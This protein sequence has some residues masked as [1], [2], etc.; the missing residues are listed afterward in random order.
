MYTHTHTHTSG[1]TVRVYVE[2]YE[3]DAA[4][5]HCETQ[6]ALKP[7]VAIALSLS[8]LHALTA[9]DAPTVIT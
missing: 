7:L 1:A 5:M 4:K 6:T 3:S 8:R 2:S 9:R